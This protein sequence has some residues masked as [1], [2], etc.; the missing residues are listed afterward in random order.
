[1]GEIDCLYET[2]DGAVVHREVAVKLF[3]GHVD[4]QLASD[5]VG[6]SKVDRLDLKLDRLIQHQIRLSRTAANLNAWPQDLPLPTRV[7]VLISGAFFKHPNHKCWPEAMHQ[8]AEQGFWC[9]SNE[10]LQL[11]RGAWNVLHKP[12]WLSTGYLANEPTLDV[13]QVARA[14]EQQQRPIFVACVE[15]SRQ[16][17]DGRGFVVPSSW[18]TKPVQEGKVDLRLG[19]V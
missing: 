15:G 4:S 9:T 5:W 12:W 1:M 16:Q 18:L 17:L 14:V 11:A 10:F 2:S 6:T 8:Q 13:A 7:E 19:P 3:L